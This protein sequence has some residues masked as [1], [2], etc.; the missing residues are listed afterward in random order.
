M[1]LALDVK[2]STDPGCKMRFLNADRQWEI[3]PAILQ[4]N[5]G[6]GPEQV[7]LRVGGCSRHTYRMIQTRDTT[8][9][10]TTITFR[11]GAFVPA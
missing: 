7:W 5:D 9:L 3:R 11:A 6:E 1:T 10:G 8:R 2:S 4:V